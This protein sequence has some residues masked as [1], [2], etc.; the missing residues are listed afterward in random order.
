MATK[1]IN[2]LSIQDAMAIAFMATS[3][4]NEKQNLPFIHPDAMPDHYALIVVGQ[5]MTPLIAAGTLLVFD[6]R[7]RPCPGD[8]VGLVF[9][10]EAAKRWDCPG[11]VKRLALALP[12]LLDTEGL[13]VVDQINPPRRYCIPTGDVLAVHKVVGTAESDGVGKAK[14]R[15]S[16]AEAWL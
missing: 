1:H 13:V 6:K 11:L 9:T 4:K 15:P 7:Q 8:I 16:K 10:R 5:C 14:W 2:T 3:F 12:D